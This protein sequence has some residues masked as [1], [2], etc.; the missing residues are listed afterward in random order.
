MNTTMDF[1]LNIGKAEKKKWHGDVSARCIFSNI[2]LPK[3]DAPSMLKT[4][5][6]LRRNKIL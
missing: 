5:I 2:S 4:N 3:N 1:V 6:Y